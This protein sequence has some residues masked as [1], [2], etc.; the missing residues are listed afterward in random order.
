MA[1]KTSQRNLAAASMR[2]TIERPRKYWT[3]M[4]IKPG[5]ELGGLEAFGQRR[6]L[7]QPVD[8]EPCLDQHVL[9]VEQIRRRSGIEESSCAQ[10]GSMCC[11]FRDELYVVSNHDHRTRGPAVD[12]EDCL[13]QGTYHVQ[14]PPPIETVRWLV[15]N[16]DP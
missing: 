3:V 9:E 15:Q 5:S 13:L 14:R 4:R 7:R 10:H 12:S 11:V 16:Q 8:P 2:W 6:K 1:T